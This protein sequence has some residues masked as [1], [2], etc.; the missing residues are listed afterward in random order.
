MINPIA[1]TQVTSSKLHLNRDF[2]PAE[3]KQLS[4]PQSWQCTNM[5]DVMRHVCHHI[6]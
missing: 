5:S 2:V 1:A 6:I 4:F 3:C